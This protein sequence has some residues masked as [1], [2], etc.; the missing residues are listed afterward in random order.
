MDITEIQA[1]LD[2]NKDTPEVQSYI[3]GL[4][5]SDRVNAFLNGDE[6]KKLLQPKLDTY[7]SKGLESWKT[8][9]LD[10]LVS[11]KVKELY[12]DADPKDVALAEMK[13]EIAKMKTDG[14]HKELTISTSKLMQEKKLPI[15]LVDFLIGSDE[16]TTAINL[17]KLEKVFSTH[18]E[19]VVA[20]RLK[21]GYVPPT[22]SG[23]P[24]TK[25]PWSKESF[26]LTEQGKLMIENPTLAS[27][28]MAQASNQ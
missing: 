23:A 26:N 20:E 13:A 9:N 21:G 1:Y 24:T 2:T 7:H 17:S 27:Q 12:P 10:N 6:G 8:N 5:T 15:E 3:G 4:I 16:A 19:A 11:A 14:L 22:G 25:N 18:I 28:Y